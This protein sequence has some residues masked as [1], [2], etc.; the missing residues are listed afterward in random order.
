MRAYGHLIAWSALPNQSRLWA[1]RK[2]CIQSWSQ[3]CGH[4]LT[5]S[6][7]KCGPNALFCRHQRESS[8]GSQPLQDVTTTPTADPELEH[9]P[10]SPLIPVGLQPLHGRLQ[11]WLYRELLILRSVLRRVTTTCRHHPRSYNPPKLVII[12]V[13]QYHLY[14]LI[15]V[16]TD[17]QDIHHLPQYLRHRRPQEFRRLLALQLLFCLCQLQ[18]LLRSR[19]LQRR[20]R[21]LELNRK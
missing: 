11:L 21:H 2:C 5:V 16:N 19:P 4:S 10:N 20:L 9:L 1:P 3:W 17:V 15:Q 13:T 12:L 7:W 18:T 6:T 14:L 8:D